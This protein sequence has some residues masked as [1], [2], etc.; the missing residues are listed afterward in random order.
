MPAGRAARAMRAESSAQGFEV[1]DTDDDYSRKKKDAVTIR[2]RKAH[3]LQLNE[4]HYSEDAPEAG[5]MRSKH[6]K[7]WCLSF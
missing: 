7:P 6:H 3:R 1:E 5:H 4:K 2:G